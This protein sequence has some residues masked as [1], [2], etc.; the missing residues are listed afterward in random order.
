M[1]S[2]LRYGRKEGS[3]K[4]KIALDRYRHSH[5]RRCR[6]SIHW[7]KADATSRHPFAQA[8]GSLSAV[9]IQGQ[10]MHALNCTMQLIRALAAPKSR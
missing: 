8:M 1:K 4:S 10:T 3:R 9:P 5:G 6:M 7:T 2:V